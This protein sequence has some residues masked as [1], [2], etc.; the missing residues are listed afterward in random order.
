MAKQITNIGDFLKGKNPLAIYLN[1]DAQGPITIDEPIV[2]DPTLTYSALPVRD[3]FCSFCGTRHADITYPMKCPGCGIETFRSPP[4]VAVAV[5]PH[6]A[7]Y[8]AVRR[9]IPP[10]VGKLAFPGGYQELGETVEAAAAREFYE[11]TGLY[12]DAADGR[13]MTSRVAGL[14]TLVFV[15]FPVLNEGAVFVPG[16]ESQ[17][18]ETVEAGTPLCFPLHQDILREVSALVS[19]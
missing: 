12:I 5:V 11:E 16:P 14:N 6:G 10:F 4:V 9:A 17:G 19:F 15:K 18:V 2:Y 1:E 8:V 7:G 13:L 3:T